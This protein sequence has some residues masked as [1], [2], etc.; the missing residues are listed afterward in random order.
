MKFGGVAVT[1]NTVD[2]MAEIDTEYILS[3][4]RM[5][6][7]IIIMFLSDTSGDLIY[8]GVFMFV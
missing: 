6:P 3:I 8:L 4:F 7:G 1:R 2:K 5:I